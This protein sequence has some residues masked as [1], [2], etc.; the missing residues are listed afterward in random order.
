MLPTP[1]LRLAYVGGFTMHTKPLGSSPKPLPI[2]SY[3][4]TSAPSP[5]C[6]YKSC[7]DT[8]L[9]RPVNYKAVTNN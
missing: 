8:R 1:T 6:T 9:V 5:K 3:S 7:G 2:L 4:F